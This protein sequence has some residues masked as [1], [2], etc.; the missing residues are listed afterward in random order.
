MLCAIQEKNKFFF[1]GSDEING[2]R[3][4][5]KEKEYRSKEIWERYDWTRCDRGDGRIWL[6][7]M[8]F[9]RRKRRKN[10]EGRL[11]IFIR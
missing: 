2:T 7:G 11:P 5:G 8:S 3:K 10:M 4:E 6:G 9:G 1:F